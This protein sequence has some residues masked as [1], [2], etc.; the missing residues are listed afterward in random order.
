MRDFRCFWNPA[1]AKCETLVVFA[2]IGRDSR[3]GRGL[4]ASQ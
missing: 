3:S 2:W 1:G 4:W